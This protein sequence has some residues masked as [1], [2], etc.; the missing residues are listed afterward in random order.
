MVLLPNVLLTLIAVLTKAMSD[1][2]AR[3]SARYGMSIGGS[4]ASLYA[5]SEFSCSVTDCAADAIVCL[6]GSIPCG[7]DLF[8]VAR[9]FVAVST[10]SGLLIV[11]GMY[12]GPLQ[13]FMPG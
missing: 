6:Y 13:T 12:R 7:S 3:G 1:S 2:L 8:H 4:R 10:L 9:S 11:S 5:P